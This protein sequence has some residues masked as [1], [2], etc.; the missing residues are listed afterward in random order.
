M[1]LRF[2]V[3]DLSQG[4]G[5]GVLEEVARHTNFVDSM[6]ARS[7]QNGTGPTADGRRVRAS[8]EQH[9]P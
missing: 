8:R 9:N 2:R 5:E 1:G 6:E 7:F 3:Q 4:F